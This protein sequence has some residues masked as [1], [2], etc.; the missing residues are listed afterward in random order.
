MEPV[1]IYSLAAGGVF[2]LAFVY[3]VS[4]SI[5]R[6]IQNR[7]LFYILKYLIYPIFIR[8]TRLSGPFSRWR[9]I[10]TIAYWIGT[11][12]CNLIGV[13]TIAQVGKRAGSLATLHLVPL[14]FASRAS[15]A[16]DLLGVSLQTFLSFHTTIGLMALVQSVVHTAIFFAHHTI[17]FKE[18]IQFYGLLVSFSVIKGP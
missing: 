18:K 6:W 11:A 9:A 1:K 14:L 16:A 2:A 17:S 13:K 5:S 8:R 7:T 10:L 3:C 15:F 4:S 12:A